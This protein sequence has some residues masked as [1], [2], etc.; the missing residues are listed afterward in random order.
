MF[1][2]NPSISTSFTFCP[3]S[4]A[5]GFSN[6]LIRIGTKISELINSC[7]LSSSLMIS[8]CGWSLSFLIQRRRSP[9]DVW[10]MGKW[11]VRCL[12]R[13]LLPAPGAP[14]W[15]KMIAFYSVKAGARRLWNAYRERKSK[16]AVPTCFFNQSLDK[17]NCG[18]LRA[19]N[20]SFLL[21]AKRSKFCYT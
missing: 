17:M 7:L 4:H 13:V 8:A 20:H 9:A 6:S 15:D 5:S 12:Q 18:E 19:Q 1:R 10:L 2:G 11:W 16:G 21:L 14:G 3:T